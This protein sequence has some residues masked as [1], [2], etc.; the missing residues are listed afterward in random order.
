MKKIRCTLAMILVL[1]MFLAV[2]G[3]ADFLIPGAYADEDIIVEE[4]AEKTTEENA[5]AAA[6]ESVEMAAEETAEDSGEELTEENEPGENTLSIVYNVTETKSSGSLVG[7]LPSVVGGEEQQAG[8]DETV[9]LR[10]LE[11][12]SYQTFTGN[13]KDRFP[14]LTYAFKGWMTESGE[15]LTAGSDIAAENLDAD[16]DGVAVL[17]SAWSGSWGS[18]S[19]TPFAKFSIWTN[20]MTA[21]DYFESNTL[22]GENASSYSPAVAGSIMVALDDEGNTVTPDELASPSHGNT[23]KP[24]VG[25]IYNNPELNFKDK[26]QGK[27]LM[28]SYM[29]TSVAEAN[30][31]IRALAETGIHT[32]DSESG[33]V[34]WKLDNLPTDEEVL[35]RLSSFVSRGMTVLR[36]ESGD[37]IHA[38][39]LTTDNY[40]VL[41]CQVKYQSGKNDGWNI[42]GVLSTKIKELQEAVAEILENGEPETS[43]EE[44]VET[45]VQETAEN[46][47]AGQET[48]ETEAAE[49]ETEEPDAIGHETAEVPAAEPEVSG[50]DASEAAPAAQAAPVTARPAATAAAV[51]AV[52]VSAGQE[53]AVMNS[54]AENVHTVSLA[55]AHVEEPS[56]PA[57]VEI[58]EEAVPAAAFAPATVKSGRWAVLDLLL[59]VLALYAFLPLFSLRSKAEQIR[60]MG[61]EGRFI[62]AVEAVMVTV[63]LISLLA[64]QNLGAPMIFADTLSIPMAALACAVCLIEKGIRRTL[65][66]RA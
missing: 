39:A 41:W 8:G 40:E 48:V 15:I 25:D 53:T 1:V 50:T 52:A 59:L 5:E 37:R 46:E 28:V 63:G 30:E 3:P 31:E 21:N 20:A 7:E 42:N 17:S 26:N 18:G 6:D 64:T 66:G 36:D 13:E 9:T 54:E 24:N 38:E 43:P 35:D 16:G 19:G 22:L 4:T 2:A 47:I 51:P 61:T 33:D 60:K 11:A 10:D 12:S 56:A 65:G 23:G 57:A 44:T 32:T 34:T 45:A 49:A 55:A 27:Y 29:Q 58:A 62:L 14:Y